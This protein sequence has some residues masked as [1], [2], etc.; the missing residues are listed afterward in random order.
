MT[1][2][3]SAPHHRREP[4]TRQGRRDRSSVFAGCVD[5]FMLVAG[6]GVEGDA[7]FCGGRLKH[8]SRVSADPLQPNLPVKCIS[9]TASF[10][11]NSAASR[12][13]KRVTRS[14]PR[15]TSVKHHDQ[16]PA[17][18]SSSLPVGTVLRFRAGPPQRNCLVAL[19]GSATGN[20]VFPD[21]RHH[22]R[23]RVLTDNGTGY[24]SKLA[25]EADRA[26]RG[27]T[28]AGLSLTGPAPT[29][30]PVADGASHRLGLTQVKV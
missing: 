19:T 5:E 16:R 30:K 28:T 29:A 21:P 10:T 15:A 26:A 18:T 2:R 11:T 4:H 12:Q 3:S 8:R 23:G 20:R 9:C 22:R 1:D 25:H 17:R 13:V 27:Q 14:R 6:M 7:H 24:R